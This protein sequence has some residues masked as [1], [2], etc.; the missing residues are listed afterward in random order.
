MRVW[1]RVV[2][3]TVSGR[4]HRFAGLRR[5]FQD[6]LLGV[7]GNQSVPRHHGQR[8]QEGRRGMEG[9]GRQCRPDRHQWR[10]HRQGQAGRPTSRTSTR[11]ASTVVLIFPG[12]SVMVAEPIKNIYNAENIPV[13]ITDI[14]I[15]SG[16]YISLIITDNLQ[17]RRSRRPTTWRRSSRR[18]A[19]SSR[20]DHAPTN[21]NGQTRQKGFEDRAKELGLEVL[22]EQPVACADARCRPPGDGGSP[23]LR[24]GR[25]G[26]VRLQP[27]RD[28]GRLPGARAGQARP[29]TSSLSASISIRCPTRWSQDGKID[30]LV[31]QD[32]Y[33]HGL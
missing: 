1:N 2:L 27:A 30:A 32:P 16:E 20:F 17:G 5:G 28:P 4:R 19:R 33:K 8:R 23:R 24:A 31:V 15:R 14:G 26:R 6:R 22:P 10:R 11:R 18:A 12:D 9:E 25:Q 13:V 29:T 21:D 7:L 3:S